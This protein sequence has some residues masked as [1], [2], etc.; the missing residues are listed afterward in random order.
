MDKVRLETFTDGVFAIV[1][2]LLVLDINLPAI[3][4]ATSL[5][6]NILR[7]LP[8]LATYALSVVIVGIYWVS[9]NLAAQQFKKIDTRVMWLNLVLILFLGLIPFT[10]SVL[11]EYMFSAWA[12]VL[13]GINILAMNLSGWL[14]ILYLYHHP[15]LAEQK[16]TV[17]RFAAQKHQYIKV[18]LLYAIGIAFAFITPEISIYIY[19]LVTTYIVLSTVIHRLSWRSRVSS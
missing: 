16:F 19:V 11:S 7:T 6:S 3:T 8:Q 2:T 17:E 1:I 10:T 12:I 5:G 18:A 14:I 9:H 15:A 13:Y 4:T